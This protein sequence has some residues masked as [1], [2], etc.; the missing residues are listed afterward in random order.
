M[1]PRSRS[2]A[3]ALL[4]AVVPSAAVANPW[5]LAPGDWYTEVSGTY[6]KADTYRDNDGNRVE[7][8]GGG[9]YERRTGLSY[10]EFGWHPK[11]GVLI[12]IPFTSVTRRTADN[13]LQS[14]ETGLGD[15]VIGAKY[16]FLNGESAL[17]LQ[18]DAIL[19]MGYNRTFIEAVVDSAGNPI[20]KPGSAGQPIRQPG[21]LGPGSQSIAVRLLGGKSIPAWNGF[22][23]GGAGYEMTFGRADVEK[24][25]EGF[26]DV[27]LDTTLYRNPYTGGVSTSPG[28]FIVNEAK[29]T[30]SFVFN[31]SAGFWIGDALLIGGHYDGRISLES[32]PTADVGTSFGINDDMRSE[33]L[34]GVTILYRVDDHIDI[35]AGSTHLAAGSRTIH[36]D[37]YY[38]ALSVKRSSLNRL[39][40]FLGN[41]QRP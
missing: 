36:A 11:L 22:I 19:P 35:M 16:A 3:L 37:R 27:A 1:M 25:A 38:V 32:T 39:Q 33:H 20:G 14:T 30:G 15:L 23:D 41:K 8:P 26:F 7:L 13:Q 28:T 6:L 17:S 5:L 24:D 29:T 21:A 4:L 9:I 40:G 2:I 18:A 34:V 31:A 10:S 12:G